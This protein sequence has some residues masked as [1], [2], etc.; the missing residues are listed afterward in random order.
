MKKAYRNLAYLVAILVVVQAA[1]IAFALFG[2]NKWIDDGHTV[3]KAIVDTHPKFTGSIGFPIHAIDGELLIPLLAISLLVVSFFAKIPGGSKWAGFVVLA[4]IVQ[5]ALG[6]AG[7][8]SAFFG[9]LHG[10]NAFVLLAVALVAG[11]R[12]AKTSL[13]ETSVAETSPA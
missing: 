5:V 13:A 4:V 3:T 11:S 7:Q 1:A 9:P 2:L 12:V 6:L 10:I 8:S